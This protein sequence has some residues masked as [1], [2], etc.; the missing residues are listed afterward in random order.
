MPQKML[1]SASSMACTQISP[2]T[3]LRAIVSVA[4]AQPDGRLSAT[5]SRWVA[6]TML[7]LI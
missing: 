3:V 5:R 1:F 7:S 4:Y 2:M 6:S